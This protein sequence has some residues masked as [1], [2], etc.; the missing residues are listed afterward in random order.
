M[1]VK[2]LQY[3]QQPLHHRKRHST[4]WWQLSHLSLAT[5]LTLTLTCHSYL[6]QHACPQPKLQPEWIYIYT[7]H[8]TLPPA[9]SETMAHATKRLTGTLL[10]SWRCTGARVCGCA[11]YF[12]AYMRG[13]RYGRVFFKFVC[14]RLSECS[15]NHACITLLVR[16][17]SCIC[18]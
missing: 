17:C 11:K 13:C 2:P 18:V 7:I 14:V 12:C 6:L 1:S 4:G 3:Q 16:V 5:I 8:S 9:L 15:R 10:M